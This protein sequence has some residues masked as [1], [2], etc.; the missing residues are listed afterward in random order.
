M[1][2]QRSQIGRNVAMGRIACQTM[3][4]SSSISL[5][6]FSGTGSEYLLHGSSGGYTGGTDTVRGN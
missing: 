3:G 6:C 4:L 1:T 5:F 2:L